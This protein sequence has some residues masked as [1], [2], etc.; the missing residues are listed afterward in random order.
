VGSSGSDCRQR[1]SHLALPVTH[2]QCILRDVEVWGGSIPNRHDLI[3]VEHGLHASLRPE[4]RGARGLTVGQVW[5]R[6]GLKLARAPAQQHTRRPQLVNERESISESYSPSTAVL[7]KSPRQAA[8][9]L[10]RGHI[11]MAAGGRAAGAGMGKVMGWGMRL[12]SARKQERAQRAP[13]QLR[14][15]ALL[16]A[17]RH[18]QRCS[19][20][21]RGGGQSQ[22]RAARLGVGGRG[23]AAGDGAVGRGVEPTSARKDERAARTPKQAARAALRCAAFLLWPVYCAGRRTCTLLCSAASTCCGPSYRRRSLASSSP[24]PP[25]NPAAPRPLSSPTFSARSATGRRS[26]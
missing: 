12:T 16:L 23:G 2:S 13:K 9:V 8:G 25:A 6:Q 5:V 15:C 7:P 10:G 3:P 24:P 1:G 19:L 20:F 26:R 22:P 4:L 11:S 18:V 21:V 17:T 14:R